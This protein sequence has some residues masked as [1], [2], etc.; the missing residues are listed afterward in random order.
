M[1]K[2]IFEKTT[3]TCLTQDKVAQLGSVIHGLAQIT[4]EGVTIQEEI[5][6]KRNP[7]NPKLFDGNYVSL[8]RNREGKYGLYLKSLREDTAIDVYALGVYREILNALTSVAR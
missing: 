3:V 1:K 2:K 7:R 8:S 5:T 4:P 6:Q